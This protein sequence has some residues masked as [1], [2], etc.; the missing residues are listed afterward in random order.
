[1]CSNVMKFLNREPPR[2]HEEMVPTPESTLP[3]AGG[4]GTGLHWVAFSRLL[5]IMRDPGLAT[6]RP[7][8]ETE[9][10]DFL[11]HTRKMARK[12]REG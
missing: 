3:T 8:E 11:L 2:K 12:R 4:G 10:P 5:L 1:V 9:C 7:R 6:L